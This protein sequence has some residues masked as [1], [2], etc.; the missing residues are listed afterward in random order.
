MHSLASVGQVATVELV[1]VTI[2]ESRNI[3]RHGLS[4][5]P[6]KNLRVEF[7]VIQIKPIMRLILKKLLKTLTKRR[8]EAPN[9]CNSASWHPQRQH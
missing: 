8:A 1:D 7:G 9:R 6:G 2:S 3:V 5:P 4:K